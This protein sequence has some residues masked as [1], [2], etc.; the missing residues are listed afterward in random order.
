[1][2]LDTVALG[3]K[4]KAIR[5]SKGLTQQVLSELVDCSPTYISYIESGHK[6]MSLEMLV[7]IANALESSTDILLADS[8]D[9]IP[10]TIVPG[11]HVVMADCSGAERR[12]LIDVLLACKQTLRRNRKYK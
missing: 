5:K 8:L 2:S 7:D 9:T 11:T 12:I 3:Q 4:I 1:M 10:A 6:T